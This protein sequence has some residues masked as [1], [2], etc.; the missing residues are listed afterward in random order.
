QF[1]TEKMK[2]EQRGKGKS[3]MGSATNAQSSGSGSKTL[4]YYFSTSSPTNCLDADKGAGLLQG[5]SRNS[6]GIKS[7][8]AILGFNGGRPG[9]LYGHL[10]SHPRAYPLLPSKQQISRKSVQFE[11]AKQCL[12][13]GGCLTKSFSPRRRTG[14]PYRP[15]LAPSR[16]WL[17]SFWAPV[18]FTIPE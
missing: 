6:V 18:L 10:A 5:K 17:K 8:A 1:A 15:P 3:A 9:S 4:G 12:D 16:Q 2:T 14:R 13:G 11:A 7:N